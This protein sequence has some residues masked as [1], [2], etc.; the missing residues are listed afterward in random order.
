MLDAAFDAGTEVG[1]GVT[2]D[3]F[4]ARHPK[5]TCDRIQTFRTRWNRLQRFVRERY[6]G[7]TFWLAPLG[8]EFGRAVEPG[9]DVLIVSSD[10]RAGG[11]RVN[12]VR[13]RRGLPPLRVVRVPLV[14]GSDGFPVSSRRIRAGVI[15]PLG[16]R[17]RPLRVRVLLAG[18][19]PPPSDPK[20]W[21]RDAF[22]GVA[23]RV[24]VEGRSGRLPARA[25]ARWATDVR[26]GAEV[27]IALVH[28]RPD[29]W[30]VTLAAPGSNQ[31]RRRQ[32]AGRGHGR[33]PPLRSILP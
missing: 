28:G 6:P 15:D 29:R 25:A 19:V 7:R 13:R 27:R 24:G 14:R 17:R 30:A 21:V 9:V 3:G 16:R 11:R 26:R 20:E 8:D 5:P 4:L 10:T 23:C 22:P 32:L 31:V 12:A 18:G 1:I 2:T 33:W